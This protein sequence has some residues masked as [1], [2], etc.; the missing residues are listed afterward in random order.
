MIFTGLGDISI[1]RS[2]IVRKNLRPIKR[3][4][5]RRVVLGDDGDSGSS[6]DDHAAAAATDCRFVWS[7]IICQK[8]PFFD[9]T[10]LL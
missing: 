5:R 2:F 1:H 3:C 4:I 10:V 7:W 8:F 6:G 9:M